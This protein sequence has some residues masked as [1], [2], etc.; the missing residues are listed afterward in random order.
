MKKYTVWIDTDWGPGGIDWD[1]ERNGL[2]KMHAKQGM[3]HWV[4][5]T[6]TIDRSP[7]K[8]KQT[9]PKQKPLKSKSTLLV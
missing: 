6:L 3:K 5:A 8:K 4:R 7:H 1:L 9:R 2:A